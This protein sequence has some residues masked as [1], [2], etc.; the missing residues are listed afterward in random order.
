MTRYGVVSGFFKQSR[1]LLKPLINVYHQTF[2]DSS[3]LKT[4]HN[5]K[6]GCSFSSARAANLAKGHSLEAAA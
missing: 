3:Y 4:R 5:H 2:I 1:H 6:T